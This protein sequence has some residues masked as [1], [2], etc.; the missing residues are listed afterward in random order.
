MRRI[1]LKPAG[2]LTRHGFKPLFSGDSALAS[3][4]GDTTY[5]CSRCGF[6]LLKGNRESAL[7]P[8]YIRCPMCYSI[9]IGA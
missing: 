3:G 8:Y 4:N 5:G 2:R 9:S 1:K 6:A 7:R